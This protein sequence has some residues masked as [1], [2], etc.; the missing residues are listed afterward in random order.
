DYGG[1]LDPGSTGFPVDMWRGTERAFVERLLPQL[2]V[3][4]ES[5]SMRDLARRLL[6]SSAEAPAGEPTVNLTAVRAERL[7]A[8]GDR[9]SAATLL[10]TLPRSQADAATA[11]LG[12]EAAWLAGEGESACAEVDD[13]IRR[14]DRD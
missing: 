13:L 3:N 5:P 4:T 8:L 1:T 2:T 12:L 11:R 9:A 6:L 10:E 7:I 14:F